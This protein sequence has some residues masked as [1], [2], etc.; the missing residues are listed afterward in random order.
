MYVLKN[1]F[2]LFFVSIVDFFGYAFFFL[3]K[4]FSKKQFPQIIKHILIIRLD[5]LGD[6]IYS[7]LLPENIKHAFPQTKIIFLTSTRAKEIISGNPFID[8]IICYDAPWF[9][10]K[11]KRLLGGK[12]F[13][14]LVKKLKSFKFDL[15]IDPRGDSRHILLMALACVNYKVGLAITGLGFL[16][17]KKVNYLGGHSLEQNLRVLKEIGVKIALDEPRLYTDGEN[18]KTLEDFL[19][20]AGIEKSDFLA[21][22]H[23][24]SGNPA[25]NWPENNFQQLARS[26]YDRYKAKIIFVGSDE[27]HPKNQSII[28]DSQ[29]K[30]VNASGKIPLKVIL[31]LLKRSSLFIGVDSAIAHLAAI[32]KVPAIILYSGTNRK[33]EWAPKNTT[34][35]Q[36][37]VIC[38]NCQKTNCEKNI[39]LELITPQE[40]LMEIERLIKR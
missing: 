37:D 3:L 6:V 4:L 28:D 13:F 17:E 33:E 7:T 14:Q 20:Q 5:H 15:G 8:E 22:I 11:N 31:E 39:C 29:V 21:V 26:I 25:K 18:I 32:A 12:S 34:V 40:V 2:Y 30:A 24:Y 16:L 35:L 9:N 10:R 36:K 19:K 38:A 27:D 23:A 1:K